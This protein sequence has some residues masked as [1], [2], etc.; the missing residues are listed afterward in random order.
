MAGAE[1]LS[2]GLKSNTKKRWRPNKDKFVKMVTEKENRRAVE[3]QQVKGNLFSW[4]R[5]PGLFAG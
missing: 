4:K 5:T 3:R 1:L 2:G